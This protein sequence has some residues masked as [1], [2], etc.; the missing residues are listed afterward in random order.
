MR[1]RGCKSIIVTIIVIVVIFYLNEEKK[2]KEKK[3]F[4][5]EK[6]DKIN[7]FSP[8]SKKLKTPS[9]NKKRNI[10]FHLYLYSFRKK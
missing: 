6:K 9:I 5:K 8:P 3:I 1:K 7:L 4:F 10:I 2:R